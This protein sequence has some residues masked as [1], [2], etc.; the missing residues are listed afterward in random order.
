MMDSNEKDKNEENKKKSIEDLDS[1]GQLALKTIVTISIG[2]C[3]FT[4]A[5]IGA[6]F[7]SLYKDNPNLAIKVLEVADKPFDSFL[8]AAIASTLGILLV[9]I[10]YIPISFS[11]DYPNNRCLKLLNAVFGILGLTFSVAA[12]FYSI[13]GFY[14]MLSGIEKIVIILKTNI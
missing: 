6:L 5:T 1:Y 3:A 11:I 12:F 14:Y 8:L 7:S 2:A 10:T 9:Y 13:S 4:L